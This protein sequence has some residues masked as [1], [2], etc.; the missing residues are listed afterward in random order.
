[1]LSGEPRSSLGLYDKLAS[2]SNSRVRSACDPVDSDQHVPAPEDLPA[3]ANLVKGLC[4]LCGCGLLGPQEKDVPLSDD[5]PPFVRVSSASFV[6]GLC[7]ALGQIAACSHSDI[8]ID[9]CHPGFPPGQWGSDHLV[10]E[11]TSGKRAL[12]LKVIGGHVE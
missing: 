4:R 6:G 10:S 2:L 5:P 3:R 12:H 7:V 1:V 8:T 9:G 11:F